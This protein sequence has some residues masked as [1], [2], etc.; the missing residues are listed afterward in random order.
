MNGNSPDTDWYHTKPK[1]EWQRLFTAMRQQYHANPTDLDAKEAMEDAA[2]ALAGWDSHKESLTESALGAVKGL[3]QAAL[4]IPRGIGQLIAHPIDTAGQLTGIANIPE[5]WETIMHND[6]AGW[7]EKLDAAIRA[8]P[9]N[10]GYSTERALLEATGAKSDDASS[11][12]EQFRRGGNVASLGLLGYK[13]PP[14]FSAPLAAAG[15]RVGGRLAGRIGAK[16]G[17]SLGANLGNLGDLVLGP[18]KAVGRAAQLAG[19]AVAG[20]LRWAA[21]KG[22]TAMAEA[23]NAAAR[24]PGI[25]NAAALTAAR[26]R[27]VEGPQTTALNARAQAEAAR[28]ANEAG[29]RRIGLENRATEIET[30]TRHA[31]GQAPLDRALTQAGIDLRGAQQARN[32]AQ[33]GVIEGKAPFDVAA[34]EARAQAAQAGAGIA[35]ELNAAKLE[36]AQG[37]AGRQ[38]LMT[39]NLEL[40]TELLRRAVAGDPP[41]PAAPQSPL[42]PTGTSSSS[43]PVEPFPGAPQ[44][45]NFGQGVEAPPLRPMNPADVAFSEMRGGAGRGVDPVRAAAERQGLITPEDMGRAPTQGPIQQNM[46]FMDWELLMTNLQ[47]LGADGF[48]EINKLVDN[49][50]ISAEEGALVAQKLQQQLKF[51]KEYAPTEPEVVAERAL[52]PLG[53][54]TGQIAKLAKELKQQKPTKKGKK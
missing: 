27:L 10:L 43:V 28:A 31:E 34:A 26:T 42:T 13:P 37:G 9:L 20:P 36:A 23:R 14:V 29:P 1:E 32:V 44:G 8:T 7:A 39:E 35:P 53:L 41:G 38:P 45:L 50:I 12:E 48:A 17:G 11:T 2:E 3:G 46:P 22:M 6:E 51:S 15:A 25:E 24:L 33:T 4:D 19:Q 54:K 30:R 21:G 52:R 5:A 16:V 49:G 47:K 18:A 40:R